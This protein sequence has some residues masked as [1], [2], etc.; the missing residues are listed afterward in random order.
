ATASDSMTV[1]GTVAK[2]FF[3]LLL[4][5]ASAAIN[6]HLVATANPLAVPLIAIGGIVAFIV[7]LVVIFQAKPNP[8][9]ISAY[10][11]GEGL[12]LGGISVL[13]AAEYQGIVL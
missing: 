11:V 5:I 13:F 12:V 8:A 4:V 10:A 9:L 6:W 7:A 2:T 3:L 1:R